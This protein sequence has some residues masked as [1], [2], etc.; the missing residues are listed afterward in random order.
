LYGAQDIAVTNFGLKLGIAPT[1]Q[2]P[3][4]FLKTC[5]FRYQ[6]QSKSIYF[7]YKTGPKSTL[8]NPVG[9]NLVT[10]RKKADSDETDFFITY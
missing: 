9:H 7:T 5:I 8:Q 1:Y 3:P 6:S 4:I 10:K 2:R